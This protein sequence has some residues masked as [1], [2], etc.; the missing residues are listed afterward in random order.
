MPIAND[1]ELQAVADEV[2]F[3]LKEIQEY[4]GDR[5]H[6]A[7]KVRF[8]R[9]YLRT[10]ASARAQIWYIQDET[11]K[12]NLAYAH[13]QADVFRWLLNRTDISATAKEMVIKE[14][15]CLAA[16]IAETLTRTVALQEKV[17]GKKKGFNDR[18]DALK[19]RGAVSS[20]TCVELKWLW[21]K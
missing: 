9:G 13:I 2:S 20:N 17:C 21:T 4:L 5:N 7:G 1:T 3:G 19:D 18:C 6:S 15:I 12:R 16:A 11:I 10:A 8:P 14:I